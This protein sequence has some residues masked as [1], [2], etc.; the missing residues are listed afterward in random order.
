MRGF[1]SYEAAEAAR[2]AWEISGQAAA[3]MSAVPAVWGVPQARAVQAA[4]HLSRWAAGAT[5]RRPDWNIT[6]RETD[7]A[8]VQ[9]QTIRSGPFAD[10][11]RFSCPGEGKPR[12]EILLLAPLSGHYATLVRPTVQGLL[13]QADVVVSD[14]HNARDIPCEA[15]TFDVEDWVRLFEEWLESAPRR[16]HVVAV[17]QPVPLALAAAAR[18]AAC[19]SSARPLSL[20]LMGGPVD[21]GTPP[22]EVSDFGRR[23]AMGTLERLAIQRVGARWPGHGRLVYPGVMQLSAFMAMN[24]SLH[25]GAFLRAWGRLMAAPDAP[26]TDTDEARFRAF[27]DEYLAV[28]DLPAEFYLSTVDRVFKQRALARGTFTVDG[29][30]VEPARISD[31]PVMVV[32]GARDDITA[33]GQCAAAFGLMPDLPEKWRAH[34]VAPGAG[35][36]GIFAGRRWRESIAPRVTEFV[37]RVDRA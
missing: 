16:R 18:M 37:R 2:S 26:D 28:M 8:P 32:E 15:G 23:A 17:C 22:T 19:H 20:V 5:V 27:Y 21:P 30:P 35:H 14:W 24:P 7:G 25:G 11:V 33:P 9:C 31:I 3:W 12:P 6:H 10:L 4:G 36:Y 1:P 13:P 34:I 29:V